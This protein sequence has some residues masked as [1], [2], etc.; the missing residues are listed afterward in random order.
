MFK[1]IILVFICLFSANAF[2]QAV[3]TGFDLSNYG[4]R[5]EPDKRVMI[6]L[7][8]LEAARTTNAAGEDVPVINTPLSPEGI[9][10]RELLKSD[11][12]ALNAD[13]RQKIS[14]FVISHKARNSKLSDAEIVAP[15]ISMAYALT[16][17]P[18]LADPI[19]TSDLPGN[20]LDVLDFA[21]LVR[22][23]Y[24]RSSIS[25]NINEYIKTYQR[26]SDARLRGS[27]REMVSELLSYLNTRPQLYFAEKIKTETQKGKSKSTKLRQIETRE[28]ERRFYIV[29]ELLAPIGNVNFLNIKDDYHAVLP[30]E[31][32][33]S[34]SEVRRGFLQFV[35][36]P[37]VNST[38]KDIETIRPAVK[39]LLDERRKVEASVSPDVYLTV[40]RSLV[41]A[42]DAKQ[43]EYLKTRATTAQARQRIEHLT[44][45][46]EKGAVA[47]ELQKYKNALADE[48]AL[49]LS[50]DYE[51]GAILVF[52][53]AEQLK[54]FEDSG[55]DIA[56]SMKEM[57]LSFDASKETGR[58]AQFADARK[59]AVAA[60]EERKKN[61]TTSSLIENPVST[62]LVEIQ[63]LI[64]A[65]NYVQANTELR[66]LLAKNPQESRIYYNIGRVASL[67][68]ESITE[69]DK[70]KQALLDAKV[71][72]ENVLRSA[73]R[74]T[75][76]ALISLSYVAL[77]KIYEFYDEKGYAA[78]LYDKA[79]QIGDVP[80][81]GHSEAIAAKAR[82]LKDQ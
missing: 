29:P 4:V 21:P 22:D 6:V 79:I 62:R 14:S 77:A 71:A 42:I 12:A 56:S 26:A 1:S 47:L 65:K 25:V 45:N 76:V 48:T 23:F 68:A 73:T 27:A 74:S 10:F 51:K 2:A 40:S 67:S 34:F 36:D 46:A 17:A 81:G 38:S 57:I 55:F 63:K 49:Q 53:F 35:V 80:N 69:I 15:F 70:Q 59:R 31:S 13:L 20:L 43:T 39:A 33:L 60:R 30:A 58:L 50:E 16:P 44:T 3:P 41:A 72:Y 28:R 82:L 37:L 11:L 32:D 5:I 66:Q 64:D 78:A 18:E 9:K 24:R 61:P 75:D 52:Y 7:A 19:V 54:G 8:T